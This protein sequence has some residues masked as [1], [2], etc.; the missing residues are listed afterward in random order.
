MIVK[1][2]PQDIF[3]NSCNHD[4]LHLRGANGDLQYVVDEVAA[5]MYVCS[6]MTKGEKGMRETL[7]RIAKKCYNDDI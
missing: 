2:N 4:I 6:Y 7:K 3:L 5:V 1:Q